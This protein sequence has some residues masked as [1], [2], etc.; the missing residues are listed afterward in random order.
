VVGM[1]RVVNVVGARPNF[2]K[3]APLHGAMRR[4]DRFS[5]VLVHTEQ[6]YDAAM[7]K[8]FFEDLAMDPPDLSLDVGSGTHA[9]QTAGVMLKLEPV[10][11]A[12]RPD[13]VLVVGDV[14]S[15]LAG[16]L[17]AAKLDIPVAHVEAGLRSFDRSMPEEINR[18]LTDVMSDLLFAPSKDAVEN[19]H[20]EG[21]AGEKVH[22]VGNVMIDSLEAGLRAAAS[23]TILTDLHLQA[24][25]Y[26]L[27]TLHRPSNVDRP[28]DLLKAAEILLDAATLLPVVFSVHPRTATHLDESGLGPRLVQ[29]GVRIIEPLGYLDFLHLMGNA[30]AVLTDSGG[31]QEETTV[32]GVP[33]ITL[34]E[35]TERPVTVM[36]GTNVV[37]G[38]DPVAVALELDRAVAADRAPSRPQGWDGH[39]ASRILT[40]LADRYGS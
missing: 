38:L 5:P 28:N 4:D 34:R 19:L 18:V 30:A 31:I 21:I 6:H 20:H 36:E 12:D 37:T 16:A 13:V 11:A 27:T 24:G 40:V 29:G 35:R 25:R 26:F 9:E 2:M 17:T 7:S 1:I 22:M 14:N 10:L 8:V 23:S 33:C 39:A 3:M 32:L 15:T